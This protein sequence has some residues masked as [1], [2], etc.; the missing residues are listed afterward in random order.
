EEKTK[1]FYQEIQR[2]LYNYLSVTLQIKTAE[3]SIDN[4]VMQLN[5]IGISNEIQQNIKD[6]L[7]VCDMSL[8][9]HISDPNSMIDLYNKAN[10]S[11][12][13]IEKSKIV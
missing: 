2:A 12:F 8:Y 13:L 1:E 3:T 7:Q 10:E 4:I 6:V 5:Q 9:A 11:I